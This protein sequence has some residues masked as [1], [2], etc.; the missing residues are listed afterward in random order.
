[1]SAPI[2]SKAWTISPN[3]RL[4]WPGTMSALLGWWAFQNLTKL[5]AGTWTMKWSCDGVTGPAN[6]GDNTNRI[7]NA[8]SFATQAAVAAAAQSYYVL[9]NPDG[10]QLLITYQGATADIAR[11][12]FST[13]AGFVLAGTTTQQPTATDEVI[14]NAGTSIVG[15]STAA[16]RVM[17][18]W[19]ADNG[20]G[21]RCPVFSAAAAQSCIS[22]DKM[23][24][25]CPVFTLPVPY[26]GGNFVKFTR[27][28][29]NEGID[30]TTP[31]Y[32]EIL[33]IAVGATNFRGFV[34]R[35]FT[36][37]VSRLCRMYGQWCMIS[38]GDGATNG[39]TLSN[40]GI[41]ATSA[42]RNVASMGGAGALVWPIHLM[43]EKTANLD[44][45]WGTLIDWHQV[46][47]ESL[48]TPILTDQMPGYEVGDV[49][50][51]SGGQ[52]GVGDARTNWWVS[53]GAATLWPWKNV[54]AVLEIT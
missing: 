17:S 27:E 39:N 3:I 25:I 43:G 37:G 36:G 16:D 46:V 24:R 19:V 41:I 11:V 1:M 40:G 6:A 47:T 52:T 29:L 34:G 48:T 28:Y 26:V 42:S 15:T 50:G 10:V 14:I 32:M 18:I 35:V 38:G 21:W 45:P 54:A 2:T 9:Q 7:A 49:P 12:S 4:A 13:Q 8:G 23:T 44:G 22:V 51:V 53:L 20:T 31:T 33:A 30:V 5:L